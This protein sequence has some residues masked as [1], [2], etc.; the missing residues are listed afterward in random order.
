MASVA[1]EDT[2]V[3]GLPKALLPPPAAGKGLQVVEH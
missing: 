3:Q 1:G 2:Q